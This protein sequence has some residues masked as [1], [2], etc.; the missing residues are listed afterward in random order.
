MGQFDVLRIDGVA[1]RLTRTLREDR[2]KQPRH[3]TIWISDDQSRLPLLIKGK[4]EYGD[5]RAELVEY[6]A[7]AP[8]QASR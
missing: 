2:R 1:Q 4:T 3:Y 5:V 8:L 7:P 6:T